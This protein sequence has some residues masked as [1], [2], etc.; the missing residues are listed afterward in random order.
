MVVKVNLVQGGITHKNNCWRYLAGFLM[1]GSQN[2]A[3]LLG[4]NLTIS[5]VVSRQLFK[6]LNALVS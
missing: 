1:C 3:R 2:G 4:L 5:S 6:V